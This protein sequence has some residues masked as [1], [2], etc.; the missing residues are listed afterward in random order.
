L[1]S[2]KSGFEILFRDHYILFKGTEIF[3]FYII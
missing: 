2:Y 1:Y 3:S